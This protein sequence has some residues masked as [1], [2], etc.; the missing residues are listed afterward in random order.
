[1]Y[2]VVYEACLGKGV[3]A[4][5]K[6]NSSFLILIIP[7]SQIFSLISLTYNVTEVPTTIFGLSH[8]NSFLLFVI[9]PTWKLLVDLGYG[10]DWRLW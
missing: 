3:I 9:V 10:I 5:G 8:F 4:G 1:M 6:P 7:P 2:D